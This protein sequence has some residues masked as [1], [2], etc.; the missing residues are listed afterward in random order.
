[1]TKGNAR[2]GLGTPLTKNHLKLEALHQVVHSAFCLQLK[3]SLHAVLV[4]RPFLAI[5][6]LCRVGL[7]G[8]AN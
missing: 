7:E 2:C 4:C 1:M 6:G 5:A 3:A 8:M